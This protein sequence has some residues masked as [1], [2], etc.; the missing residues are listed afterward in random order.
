MQNAHFSGQGSSRGLTDFFFFLF[1]KRG[2]KLTYTA[3]PLDLKFY[4]SGDHLGMG[5]AP[6]KI[7]WDN[8]E[9]TM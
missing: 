8:R 1:V 2:T 3:L 7:P 9:K 6:S 5:R 4:I